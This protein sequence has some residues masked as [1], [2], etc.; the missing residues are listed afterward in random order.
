ML[1][2]VFIQLI[3]NEAMQNIAQDF[4]DNTDW[5]FSVRNGLNYIFGYLNSK[6]IWYYSTVDETVSPLDATNKIF[7]S[8]HSIQWFIFDKQL[9][10]TWVQADASTWLKRRNFYVTA[11]QNQADYSFTT[12]GN[13][14]WIIGIK[15]A[16][17]HSSMRLIYKRWPTLPT[18]DPTAL[19]QNIDLPVALQGVLKYYCL[20]S[21]F[22][23]YLE[24][25]V[26]LS[27]NYFAMMNNELDRYAMTIGSGVDQDGFISE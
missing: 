11:N 22:P 8:T 17:P 15:T 26:A 20:W 1:L 2:S 27:Q 4:Y 23:V 6:N 3:K 14:E 18:F 19:A 7:N 12:Y 9:G 21:V 10:E 24:N 16:M 25:G 13:T 5:I